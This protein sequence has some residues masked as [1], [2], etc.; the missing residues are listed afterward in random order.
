MINRLRGLGVAVITP[1]LESG[2]I[3]FSNLEKLVENLIQNGVD[4]LVALGT[5]SEIPTLSEKEKDEVVEHIVRVAQRRVPVIRGVGGPDT[6]QV[7]RQL[8]EKDFIGVDA[9]LSVAPYYS[10]PSQ[11]GLYRHYYT[12]SQNSPLPIILYNVP[13]RTGCNIEA[14]TTIRI[15]ADCSNIIAIKE[16]SG[17]MNQIMRVI[18]HKPDNFVVISGDDAITLPLMAVGAIGVIS[19]VANAFPKE[20][21]NMVHAALDENYAVARSEHAALLDITQACFKEGN[22]AGVKAFMSMQGKITNRLR[23]PQVP[24]SSELYEY[25]EQLLNI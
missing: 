18:A 23:L 14:D 8:Q 22:P 11:E 15:A 24:V 21:S 2:E 5:T 20:V 16:A 10:R 6:H 7:V 3:D 9:I 4:Y 17:N 12:L 13:A 25:M 19:V 1:F